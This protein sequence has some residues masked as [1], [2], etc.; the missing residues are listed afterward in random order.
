[1]KYI[2]I[3]FETRSTTDLKKSGVYR[4]VEDPNTDVWCMAYAKGDLE[5][6]IWIPPNPLPPEIIYWLEEGCALR[7]WNAQFERIIWNTICQKYEFPQLP[8]DRFYCTAADALAMGLPGWLDGAVKA[9]RL[10]IEKDM[11]GNRLALQ[12]CKP[13][14]TKDD[15]LRWWDVPDKLEH[16]YEYC[17]QDVRAEVAAMGATRRLSDEE[18]AVYLLDQTINDRGVYLDQPLAKRVKTSKD[19]SSS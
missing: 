3:D 8:N 5:P 2:N 4:Y 11:A 17:K 15:S 19:K 13:R 9:L 16:L 1:M 18:R 10:K 14:K 7:A 6:Q 12:M